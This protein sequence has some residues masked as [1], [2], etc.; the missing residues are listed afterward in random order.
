MS[1]M[2]C[3]CLIMLVLGLAWV[4]SNSSPYFC[5]LALVFTAGVACG[6]LA[7]LGGSF[8]SL[9]LFLMYVGGMLVVFGYSA[10]LAADPFPEFL[11]SF[12]VMGLMVFFIFLAVLIASVVWKLSSS[13]SF[14]LMESFSFNTTQN[15]TSGVSLMYL[16]GGAMLVSAGG[17][18]L[19]GLFVVLLVT[20]GLNDAVLRLA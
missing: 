13:L 5:A 19:L 1:L 6:L 14:L 11:G 3:V 18:L 12:Y 20:R 2:V 15:D 8:F 16:Y 10:A 17:V 9:I 7:V 4:A